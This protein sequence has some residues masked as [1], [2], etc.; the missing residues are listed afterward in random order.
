MRRRM[1]RLFPLLCVNA[2]KSG[3]AACLL[4][5]AM[6]FA[7]ANTTAVADLKPSSLFSDG[8]VLQRDMPI[9]VWGTAG[10]G[11][12]V[13]VT[14]QGQKVS[15]TAQAGRWLVRLP[16][17]KAG[18]PFTM[19]ISGGRTIEIKDILVGEVWIC[20]GQSNMEMP[21][22][23][24]AHA[25]ESIASSE[26]S[27]LR[28]F[29]VPKVE[30][31][32]NHV[33]PI[34]ELTAK[35]AVCQPGAVSRFSGVGYFFGRKLRSTL[36]VPVGLIHI[37]FGG[38]YAALW[39]NSETLTA[40]AGGG[41]YR[42]GWLYDSMLRP[43]QP[44]A[45]RGVIWYQGESD[46]DNALRYRREFPAMIKLWR[47][48]WGQGSFPFLFVQLPGFNFYKAKVPVEPQEQATWAELREVQSQ[49]AATVANTAMVV[50]T[51][52]GDPVQL[53]APRKREV[54]ERLALTAQGLVYGQDIPYQS[55]AFKSMAIKDAQATVTFDHA[56]GG[57]IVRGDAATGFT[58]A[59]EDG[60][61]HHAQATVK[62]SAVTVLSPQVSRP[63]AV[64]Y[65]WANY[66][67]TNL[68]N[69]QGLPASPFR[70]DAF[71]LVKCP[72]CGS[73][74]GDGCTGGRCNKCNVP[75]APY[76]KP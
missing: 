43:L 71:P 26:D 33:G 14:F 48:D 59:G 35:W 75:C 76:D 13:T 73:R 11:E 39:L 58:I 49:T 54:G 4:L 27:M 60:V 15:T 3:A 57:L 70:T 24:C 38:S 32:P 72:Q 30:I 68:F 10:D 17:L 2:D 8:A 28:L 21:V 12:K 64:R 74:T 67:R 37:S 50:T 5:A 41:T 42:N 61:F 53:H 20:S 40:L 69:T 44:Y 9:P 36:N 62:G 19:T 34:P 46:A 45:M 16:P 65:G 47:D 51:D 66:P 55:P 18:G 6:G 1:S 29:H 7:A 31:P 63:V 22:S 25:G 56:T 52:V 23:E